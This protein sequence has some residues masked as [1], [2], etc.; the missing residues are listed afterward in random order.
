[1]VSIDLLSIMKNLKWVYLLFFFSFTSC[2]QSHLHVQQ[3]WY[4]RGSLASS[5]V[6]TPDPR[7]NN[8]PNG[9]KLVVSWDY[10]ISLFQKNTQL[11]VTVRFWD[12]SEKVF[13]RKIREKRGWEAFV[14]EH[15]VNKEG[16]ILTYKVEVR[17][18]KGEVIDLWKHQFWTDK[19]ILGQSEQ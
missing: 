17:N 13:V 12:N 4:N 16:K 2:Y 11:L 7:Q 3:Q 18:Q 6:A 9:Q 1:M 15:N 19:V 14:F 10:P 5:W 8:P